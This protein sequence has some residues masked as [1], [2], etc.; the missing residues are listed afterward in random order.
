MNGLELQINI[1]RA[2]YVLDCANE[3]ECVKI[4]LG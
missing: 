3:M 1:K 2:V 4:I